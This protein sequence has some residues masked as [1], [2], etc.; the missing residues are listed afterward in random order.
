LS[1]WT[2]V[3]ALLPVVFLGWL[4]LRP[5]FTP[6][7]TLPEKRGKQIYFEG[8]SPGD[9]KITAYI[10]KEQIKLP[11]S[12]ATCASCH[13]PDGRGRPE[14][15]VIPSDLTWDHLMKSYGH[16]HPKGRKHPAFTEA[17]LKRSIL[18]GDDPAGNRLDA[19]MPTYNMS[20]EDI[21][22][23][24]AYMKRME[25]DFDPGLADK[26]IRIGTMLP[27]SGQIATIGQ[28]MVEVM[29][30]YFED[31][32]SRGGIYNRKLE[33]VASPYDSNNSGQ[34]A[35]SSARRLIEEKNV[36]AI[37]GAVIAGADREVTKLAEEKKI[38]LI[39]PLTFFST[40]QFDFHE[41]TFYLLSGLNEQVRALV[42]FAFQELNLDHPRIA[43]IGLGDDQQQEL[44]ASVKEQSR[45]HG[46]TS[47]AGFSF[48][49]NRFDAAAA[50]TALRDQRI[51]ALFYLGYSGLDALIQAA[52]K[53]NWRPYIFM[54][55]AFAKKE[56][57]TLPVNFQAKIYLSYPTLPSD[58][59]RDGIAELQ[60]LLE[61]QKLTINHLTSQISALTA[62]KILVEGLKLAGRDLSREKFI[63][64]L[65]KLYE[66][67]TG[68]TPPITY[69]PNR[70]I[71]ALGAHIVTIDLDKKS[72]V[73][74]GHWMPL[75]DR[76]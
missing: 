5:Y 7:L 54:P 13:G 72:F 39:G 27:S 19:S 67:S 32:N 56:M 42:D 10:G 20:V 44:Q 52:E 65:E 25:T 68:L 63:R 28:G 62:A 49:P 45:E 33:L 4:F 46:W 75:S 57:L 23:L 16:S 9:G 43:V 15:G 71:G 51:E 55:A 70:R 37:V 58:Q 60:R 6:S 2:I 1:P 8:T 50:A 17:S 30:V 34:S 11:G 22:D 74:V 18:N 12:A 36:F 24:V 53:I 73:P 38:P 35:I 3:I 59:T 31:I 64:S 40:D 61:K 66:F 41:Y 14:A 48:L 21:N 29:A 47:V 69:G 26:S 76:S